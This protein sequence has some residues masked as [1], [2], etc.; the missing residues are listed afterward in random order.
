MFL[1]LFIIPEKAQQK[2][3][4]NQKSITGDTLQIWLKVVPAAPN[5]EENGTTSV[6]SPL[7]SRL[8]LSSQAGTG[9]DLSVR[10]HGDA[11]GGLEVAGLVEGGDEVV[12]ALQTHDLA[13]RVH[14]VREARA[15]G[16]GARDDGGLREREAVD[17]QE[18][19]GLLGL[20][21]PRLHGRGG[22]R[23]LPGGLGLPLQLDTLRDRV[24]RHRRADARVEAGGVALLLDGRLTVVLGDAL[25][26]L[27]ELG[28]ALRELLGLRVGLGLDAGRVL[29]VEVRDLGLGRLLLDVRGVH[30]ASRREE[31]TSHH[32]TQALAQHDCTSMSVL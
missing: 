21:L 3:P 5:S 31:E 24:R 15:R 16:Q 14:V 6:D 2:K 25:H 26:G 7:M 17:A 10:E 12:T 22:L 32:Q 9:D 30:T 11:A 1:F 28:R 20:L 4:L 29:E 19:V 18:E 8:G 13:C 23:H 27:G